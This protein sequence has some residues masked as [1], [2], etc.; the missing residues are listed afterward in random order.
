M[1]LPILLSVFSLTWSLLSF[2]GD[3]AHGDVFG[4]NENVF[5]IEFVP[6]GSPR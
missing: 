2:P 3:I 4:S 1:R 6:F 5:Q